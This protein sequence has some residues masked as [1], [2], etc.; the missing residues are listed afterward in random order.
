[1]SIQQSECRQQRNPFKSVFLSFAVVSSFCP[2]LSSHLIVYASSIELHVL[3]WARARQLDDTALLR[4]NRFSISPAFAIASNLSTGHLRSILDPAQ[5]DVPMRS[6]AKSHAGRNAWWI[7]SAAILASSR[8]LDWSIRNCWLKGAALNFE[9]NEG[10]CLKSPMFLR[11][12]AFLMSSNN[13]K[14]L[15]NKYDPPKQCFC[16]YAANLTR[17][18]GSVRRATRVLDNLKTSPGE[19]RSLIALLMKHALDEK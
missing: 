11:F 8:F 7:L 6:P 19:Y 12:R 5:C 1:M 10:L 15:N 4:S 14:Y 3:L 17:E 16:P 2:Q 9:V 18:G 13:P